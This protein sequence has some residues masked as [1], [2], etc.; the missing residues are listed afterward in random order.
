MASFECSDVQ[1]CNSN[2]T[3]TRREETWRHAF[4]NGPPTFVAHGCA[5]CAPLVVNAVHIRE[6]DAAEVLLHL[7]RRIH[8]PIHVDTKAERMLQGVYLS[9]YGTTECGR[10]RP[11][12]TGGILYQFHR[13]LDCKPAEHLCILCCGNESLGDACYICKDRGVRASRN[14]RVPLGQQGAVDLGLRTNRIARRS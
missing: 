6:Q 9:S 1:P 13:L 14:G 8:G 12:G 3:R 11:Q 5:A 7:W 10:R 2:S 4:I